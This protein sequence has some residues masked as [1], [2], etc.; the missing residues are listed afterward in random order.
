MSA[1][2]P[3]KSKPD[4]KNPEHAK[5]F[6]DSKSCLKGIAY[7]SEYFY[8]FTGPRAT[9][10]ASHIVSVIP[11]IWWHLMCAISKT[12]VILSFIKIRRAYWSAMSL[13]SCFWS[14]AGAFSL[15]IRDSTLEYGDVVKHYKIRALDN[16]GYYISPSTTFTSLQE[17]VEH[18]SS[19]YSELRLLLY[20]GAFL[21]L[22]LYTFCGRS[23]EN[24]KQLL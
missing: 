22:P 12:F 8:L 16:G 20:Q 11:V 17:L 4:V 18:Y 6:R 1:I 24:D 10:I 14:S 7:F 15:S 9:S 2:S 21:F 3:N 13:N 19:K 23:C 5:W